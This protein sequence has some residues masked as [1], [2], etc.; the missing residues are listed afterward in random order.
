M[1]L[2][3]VIMLWIYKEHN[4]NDDRY[5][6]WIFVFIW[7]IFAVEFYTTKDYNVYYEG[8][9]NPRSQLHWEFLYRNLNKLFQPVGYVVMNACISAFEIYTLCKMYKLTVKPQYRWIGILIFV[10]DCTTQMFLYMNFKR[11]FFA[12]MASLWII[13]F[14]LYYNG[15]V[16]KRY[17]YAFVAFLCAINIHSAAFITVLYFILPFVKFRLNK[18]AIIG[19]LLLFIGSYTF[20]LSMYM[21]QLYVLLSASGSAEDYYEAYLLQQETYEDMSFA[22]VFLNDFASVSKLILLLLFNKSFDDKFFKLVLLSIISFALYNILKGNFYRIN[23]F[24]S[25]MNI[26]T[27]PMLCN[28]IRNY[29]GRYLGTNITKYVYSIFLLMILLYPAKQY[30]NAMTG[31]KVTFMTVKYQ[32]FYNIFDTNPDTKDYYF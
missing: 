20:K 16:L 3:V 25:M 2:L 6:N 32:Y 10:L 15:G 12:M 7:F 18:I 22:S 28:A 11:Q 14:L 23:L 17:L 5:I 31:T 27:I 26:F 13:Y 21:N 8:F 4:Y 9:Y 30:Y 29:K 1:V 19:I 24:F